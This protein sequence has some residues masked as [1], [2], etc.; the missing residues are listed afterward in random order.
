VLQIGR[1][2]TTLFVHSQNALKPTRS[3]ARG[4]NIIMLTPFFPGTTSTVTT[5]LTTTFF[6][7]ASLRSNRSRPARR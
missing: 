5:S 2:V 7:L 1:P 4:S 6:A 3:P